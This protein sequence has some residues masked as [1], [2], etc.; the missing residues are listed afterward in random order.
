MSNLVI[1]IG[2]TN[3]VIGYFVDN[4][5]KKTWRLITNKKAD[6]HTYALKINELL[7]ENSIS[8]SQLDFIIFSSVVPELN[9]IF[10][11]LLSKLNDDTIHFNRDYY[12]YLDL[13]INNPEEIGT[14]LVANS[15]AAKHLYNSNCIIVDFGTALTFTVVDKNGEIMGVNIVPGIKTA[16]G[17]LDEKTSQ[18]EKVD[19]K[20]PKN[21]IGQNTVEAI[22]NGILIGYEGLIK[23]MIYM[24]KNYF[25][26][27]YKVVFTGGLSFIYKNIIEIDFFEKDLTL[28]GLSMAGKLTIKR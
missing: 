16:I 15:L 1:D 2:N 25:T 9:N 17:T 28:I 4:S 27:D 11:E 8:T 21:P 12:K 13:K 10:K 5:L 20:R 14:D 19:I 24:L 18:L 6:I 26:D 22:Q 23:H 7:F 3:I